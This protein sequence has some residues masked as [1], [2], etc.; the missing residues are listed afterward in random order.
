MQYV[1]AVNGYENT[2]FQF[3]NSDRASPY[4]ESGIYS[5]VDNTM[6]KQYIFFTPNNT[7][8]NQLYYNSS[9]ASTSGVG[10]IQVMG[11]YAYSYNTS[12]SGSGVTFNAGSQNI[13]ST[14]NYYG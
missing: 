9:R 12:F 14:S 10:G 2:S 4:N 3:L 11:S 6:N 8:P 5:I 7:T 13:L 1:F